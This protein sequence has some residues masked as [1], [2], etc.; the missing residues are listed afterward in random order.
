VTALPPAPRNKG[1]L[2]YCE[3][4]AITVLVCSKPP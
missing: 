4:P 2:P 3:D 1:H